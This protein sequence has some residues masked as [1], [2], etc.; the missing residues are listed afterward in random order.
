MKIRFKFICLILV[1][2][3]ASIPFFVSCGPDESV[4]Q[5]E[6]LTENDTEITD[7]IMGE[8]I[9]EDIDPRLLVHDN[10]PEMDFGGANFTILYPAWS[11]YVLGLYFVEDLH[12][13]P[14]GGAVFMRQLNVEERFNVNIRT[15]R[16]Y[17]LGQIFTEINR[18]VMAG[19]NAYDLALTHC[20]A[21]I[22]SF[23]T[24]AVAVDW[25]T[26][27]H[28]DFDKPWWNQR[29]NDELSIFGVLL[30]AVSD[31]IIFDPTVIFFNKQMVEDFAF[32]CPYE[33]VRSYRWT[34]EALYEMAVTATVDLDGNGIFNANDQFGFVTSGDWVLES[35]LPA[36]G[37]STTVIDEDGRR[38]LNLSNEHF[39]R[40]IDILSDLLFVGNQT[41]IGS[42]DPNWDDRWESPVPMSSGRAL[43]H[44]DPLSVAQR[45]RASEVDFGI[46]PFPKREGM[47]EYL[48][49]S[50]NGFMVIPQTADLDKVGVITEA[51]AAQSF[52]YVIPAYYDVLLTYQL[53]RDEESREMLDI[54]FAG[55]TYCFAMNFGNWISLTQPVN[56]ILNNAGARADV[57]SFIE[58]GSRAFERH[59]ERIFDA[60]EAN[61]LH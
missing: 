4:A 30:P 3:I 9:T 43:F 53:V 18:M 55:A 32:E 15:R 51:L 45:I 10:L 34:W 33:L 44:T 35:A 39:F 1:L 20:I 17:D 6:R 41:F 26:V 21:G 37:L 11:N 42:W 29:M 50:W 57:A 49:L 38:V 22:F 24:S 56:Q 25:N 40:L 27:P 58:R 8:E 46:L 60:V 61:Y 14:L 52:R 12:E 13:D 59:F 19:D 2:V 47:N 7:N 28:V 36:F 54:I 31:F 23:A 16:V 5:D 48:S